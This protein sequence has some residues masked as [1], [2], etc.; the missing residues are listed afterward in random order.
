[1][2]QQVIYEI[3]TNLLEAAKILNIKNELIAKISDQ[4]QKLRPGFVLGK[5]GRILEWDRQ[6]EEYEP[7][8]RH[9]SHLYLSLIHI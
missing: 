8:H 5:E 6:Y 9:M 4:L 1:M 3:F 2:D 7:G